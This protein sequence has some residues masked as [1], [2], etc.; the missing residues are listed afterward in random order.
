M[1]KREKRINPIDAF[2]K[3]KFFTYSDGVNNEQPENTHVS[4]PEAPSSE[5]DVKRVVIYL[6]FSTEADM[7]SDEHERRKQFL[8]EVVNRHPNWFLEDIYTD[9]G[10]SSKPRAGFS[11]MM[12]DC[13]AGKI[14]VIVTK[15]M[16]QFTRSLPDFLQ[17]MEELKSLSPPVGVLFEK[18]GIYTLD[19][20]WISKG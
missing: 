12:A 4:S 16:S 3:R 2:V 6:R 1:N 11:K 10:F 8:Q 5:H 20:T 19:P 14:D 13:K 18:E 9:M 15:S 7:L 17:Y